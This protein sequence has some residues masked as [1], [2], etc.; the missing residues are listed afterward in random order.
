MSP[1]IIILLMFSTLMLLMLTGQRVFG[2][3]G[4]VGVVCALWLW[5]GEGGAT[6]M[7]FNAVI[8]LFDWYPM[9][10]LPMFIFMGYML[11]E[12]GIAGDL[13]QMLHVWMG[14]L[15]GGL[16]IG[17]LFLQVLISCMNGLSVAGMAIGC[18][19]ALPELVKRNY[20]KR[21]ISGLIQA[22]SS[23]GILVPPSVVLVLY[24]MI[25]R[26]PVADLWLAGVVPGLLM[27]AF[28]LVYIVVR[29]HLQPELGP[30]IPKEENKHTPVEKLKVL[31][32]GILP[33]LL[34]LSVIGSFFAGYTSL[35]GSAAVGAGLSLVIA[36]GRKRLSKK[37]LVDALRQ[38]LNSSAMF[39]WVMMAA[40]AFAAVFDGLGAVRAI[41]SLFLQ[42]LGMT[43]WQVLILM[44]ISFVIMGIF[45]DDTAMLIIVAPLYIPIINALGFSPVWFGILYTI[46]CQ[47]AYLT[48][49]FGYNLFLMRA[50]SPPDFKIRDIYISVIPFVALMFLTLMLIMVFP[51]IALWLPNYIASNAAAK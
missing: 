47:I 36:A 43:P 32:A 20:D 15:R 26:Q 25:A 45:L 46:T 35:V 9:L 18:S 39:M 3:M 17:T 13:Y 29:C 12:S 5:G 10:T 42:D 34:V 8:K 49:P 44:Q 41:E 7:G 1:E 51:E 11:A 4:F 31:S 2:A 24:A 19:V 28:F 38:T 16:G 33:L 37:V 22:S 48:P 14:S 23:L 21:M 50:M 30:A 27:A 40:L 6:D